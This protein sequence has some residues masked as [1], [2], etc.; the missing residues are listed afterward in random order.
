[1]TCAQDK[2]GRVG[3]N[4]LNRAVFRVILSFFLIR[5]SR[6]ALLL[7]LLGHE[8]VVCVCVYIKVHKLL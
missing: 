4:T 8:S 2:V 7:L 3:M 1:M 6:V 5:E